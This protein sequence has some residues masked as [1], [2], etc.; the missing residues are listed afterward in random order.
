MEI[1]TCLAF[2][3]MMDSNLRIYHP[4]TAALFDQD[5]DR[6][7]G[8][9]SVRGYSKL[10]TAFSECRTASISGFRAAWQ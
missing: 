4:Y 5:T 7:V 6:A 3:D 2:A 1:S 8:R 9:G 10:P